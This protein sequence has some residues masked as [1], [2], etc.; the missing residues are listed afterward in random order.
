MEY[1]SRLPRFL[2]CSGSQQCGNRASTAPG[3]PCQIP[4]QEPAPLELES[5]FNIEFEWFAAGCTM[6]TTCVMPCS[7]NVLRAACQNGRCVALP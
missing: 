6:P 1:A 4:V 5:L 3:C 7:T 2:V